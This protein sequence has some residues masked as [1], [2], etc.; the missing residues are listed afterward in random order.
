MAR[1]LLLIPTT[2]YRVADFMAA[3]QRLGVAVTV[4]SNQRQVLEA[5]S[6]GG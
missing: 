3:A 6:D 2:S 4:G 5:F 1:L